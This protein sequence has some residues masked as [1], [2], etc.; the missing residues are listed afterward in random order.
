MDNKHGIQIRTAALVKRP[1]NAPSAR[2]GLPVVTKKTN[3]KKAKR[4]LNKR[5]VGIALAVILITLVLLSRTIYTYNL[6]TVTAVSPQ[7]G[8]LNKLELTTGIAKWEREDSIYVPLGGKVEELLVKEGDTLVEGQPMARLSFDTA[9]A[10]RKLKEIEVSRNKLKLDMQSISLRIEKLERSIAE[11]QNEA[12]KPDTVS[13]Y[14]I[15]TTKNDIAKAWIDY[16]IMQEKFNNGDATDLDVSKAW[17]TLQGLY[18]KLDNLEKTKAEREQTALEDLEKKEKSRAKQ[19]ADYH[20]DKDALNLDLKAKKQDS[21]NLDIQE[22]QYRKILEESEVC[23]QITA[24][25]NG[26]VLTLPVN[27]GQTVNT[28]QLFATVGVGQTFMIECDITLDNNFVAVGDKCKMQNATHALDGVVEKIALLERS[29][30]VT[31]AVRSDE[32]MEGETFEIRLEKRSSVS[33]TLVP[34]GAVNK[35]SDGY[36]LYQLKRRDGIMGKEF[37]ATKLRVFIGDSDAE[38]TVIVQGVDFFEPVVLLSDKPF[39][40]NDTIK[41]KNMGDFFA[42]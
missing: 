26:T 32:I 38:N 30:K 5:N 4:I 33:Y 42:D 11:L 24:P 23:A 13:D 10:E 22:A 19:L 1:A 3:A 25:Q 2:A 16:S 17:L 37:Y 27:Q 7:N 29:K 15:N 34:N 18:L 39:E 12:Y 31:I 28:A 21:A 6:P 20:S 9:D 14:D 36:F 35:D 8:Q 40:E 41:V